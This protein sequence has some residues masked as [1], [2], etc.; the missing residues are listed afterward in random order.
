MAKRQGRGASPP[1]LPRR[2]SDA[3][4]RSLDAWP[5]ILQDGACVERGRI[6]GGLGPASHH[7]LR[8]RLEFLDG[9]NIH[10]V[11]EEGAAHV[12]TPVV[13]AMAVTVVAPTRCE[14]PGVRAIP[15]AIEGV[16]L[17]IGACLP[18]GLAIGDRRS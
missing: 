9:P 11:A 18:V 8:R 17:D 3:R 15:G 7:D 12:R 6:I 5:E 13:P 14:V 1:D 4:R 16:G 2:L 10:P